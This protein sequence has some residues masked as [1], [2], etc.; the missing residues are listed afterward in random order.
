MIIGGNNE[1]VRLFGE[2][3]TEAADRVQWL[4][5]GLTT[6]IQNA[7]VQLRVTCKPAVATHAS[8]QKFLKDLGEIPTIFVVA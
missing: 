2:V 8:V 5:Q 7:V 6:E 3:N 1:F 4:I